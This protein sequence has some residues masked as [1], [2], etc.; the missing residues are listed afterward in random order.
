MRLAIPTLKSQP[1]HERTGKNEPVRTAEQVLPSLTPELKETL[2]ILDN[3]PLGIAELTIATLGLGSRLALQGVGV[4]EF[5]ENDL[6]EATSLKITKLGRDVIAACAQY[7]PARE[8]VAAAREQA[9]A[10]S[11]AA[12]ESVDE[13]EAAPSAATTPS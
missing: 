13:V 2:G 6:E 8:E 12:H 4:V 9:R 1:S 5:E 3:A 7:A 10:E 11:D